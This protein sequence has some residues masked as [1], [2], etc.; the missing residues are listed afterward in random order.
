MQDLPQTQLATDNEVLMFIG[1]HKLHGLGIGYIDAHLL[2]ATKLTANA[3]FWTLDKRLASAAAKL[4][5]I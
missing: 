2:V 4:S 5:L 1:Q 3:K